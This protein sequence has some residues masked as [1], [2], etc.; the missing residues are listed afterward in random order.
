MGFFVLKIYVCMCELTWVPVYHMGARDWGARR[1][2]GNPRTSVP[3][4]WEPPCGCWELKPL[5]WAISPVCFLF[6][7]NRVSLYS[8]GWPR[9]CYVVGS[10]WPWPHKDLLPLPC[11]SLLCGWFLVLVFWDGVSQDWGWPW[12]PDSPT[13]QIVGLKVCVTVPSI[14][15][16]CNVLCMCVLALFIEK[17]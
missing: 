5:H 15:C 13:S 6:V 4:S 3:G 10:G 1:G 12:S 14:V 8:S 16:F 17:T 9:I 11:V 2:C 7:G